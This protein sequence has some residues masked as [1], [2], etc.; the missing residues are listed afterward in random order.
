MS[1]KE[2]MKN[3]IVSSLAGTLM[4]ENHALSM[5][6]ALA[7][8]FNSGTCQKL[9]NDRTGLYYQSPGYVFSFLENELKTGKIA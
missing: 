3:G 1:E 8:A 7:P 6:Q 5:E 4:S 2:E 9:L